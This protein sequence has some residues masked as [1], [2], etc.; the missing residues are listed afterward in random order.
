[1]N[2]LEKWV[3]GEMIDKLEYM[4]GLEVC[5]CE[6]ALNLFERA[7]CDGSY[8]YS[9][10]KAVQWCHQF[11]RQLGDAVEDYSHDW[12]EPP[13]NVFLFPE[14]F[15]V[16]MILYLADTLATSSQFIA[17]NWNSDEITLTKEVIDVIAKEWHEAIAEDIPEE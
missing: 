2:D 3:L 17:E 14:R 11:F 10:S 8:T 1:M 15:Q 4:E 13:S 9:T 16:Q 12:G 6:L 5:P 7:N